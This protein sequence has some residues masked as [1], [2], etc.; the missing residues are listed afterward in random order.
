MKD[1]LMNAFICQL[2][3]NLDGISEA[4]RLLQQKY[5]VNAAEKREAAEAKANM[6]RTDESDALRDLLVRKSGEGKAE[7]I[8]EVLGFFHAERFSE[9]SPMDYPKLKEMVEIL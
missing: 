7:R 5:E 8:R 1:E 2:I 6:R 3:E 4:L 9:I